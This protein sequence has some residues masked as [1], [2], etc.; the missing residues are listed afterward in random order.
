MISNAYYLHIL[1]MYYVHGSIFKYFYI[2]QLYTYTMDLKFLAYLL[3][4][5]QYLLH[6]SD[7]PVVIVAVVYQSVAYNVTKKKWQ[8][9][10]E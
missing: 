8:H 1:K 4:C 6:P 5:P 10:V 7:G 9:T 2:I 3:E